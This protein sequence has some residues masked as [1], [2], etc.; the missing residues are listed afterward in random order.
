MIWVTKGDTRIS[1]IAHVISGKRWGFTNIEGT[2]CLGVPLTRTIVFWGLHWELFFFFF[3]HHHSR[4]PKFLPV[5]LPYS[6]RFP[7]GLPR[8]RNPHVNLNGRV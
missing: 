1:T 3:P 2:Y 5:L 4:D 6:P 7:D 8:F